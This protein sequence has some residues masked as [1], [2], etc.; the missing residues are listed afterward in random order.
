MHTMNKKIRVLHLIYTFDIEIGGGGLTMFATELSKKLDSS[1]F[2]I[3]IGSLGFMNTA[4]GRQLI[5]QLQQKNIEAFQAIDWGDGSPF[6]NFYRA[7]HAIQDYL[8]EHPTD[9]IHSHSE[10]TDIIALFLKMGKPDLKVMRTVHYAAKKEWVRKPL[11]RW[12]FTNFLI[13]LYFDQEIGINNRVNRRLSNR[14]V[15]RLTGKRPI[16]IYNAIDIERLKN[17]QPQADRIRSEFKIPETAPIFGSIGR[18]ARQKGYKYLIDAAKLVSEK[19]PEARLLIIGEGPLHDSLVQQAEAL[20]IHDRVIFT[21]PRSDISDLLACMDIFV[22]SSLAEGLPTVVMESMA[23]HTPVIA[24]DIPG[25]NELIRNGENGVLVPLNH[26][27][28]MSEAIIALLNDPPRQASLAA[29]AYESL[30]PFTM[31]AIAGQHEKLYR[32]MLDIS[33][34]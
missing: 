16:R 28:K 9:I 14:L 8:H 21:G 6:K 10:F 18:L 12:L 32:A 26:P 4:S 29:K 17:D 24:T 15:T 20:N 7:F 1:Q 30:Q 3:T 23:C 2:D 13:P 5:D 22:S 34:D 31:Q 27:Q 25:N 19:M 33:L 11:R